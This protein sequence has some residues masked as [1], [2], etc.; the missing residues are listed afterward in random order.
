VRIYGRGI[1]QVDCVVGATDAN[2]NTIAQ[3]PD[4][5]AL[6]AAIANLPLTGGSNVGET[7]SDQAI[8]NAALTAAGVTPSSSSTIMLVGLAVV[9]IF[10][11]MALGK[12]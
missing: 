7:S 3:C 6:T 12:R 4:P 5:A 8:A 1:G 10:A 11:F 2:G 9:G